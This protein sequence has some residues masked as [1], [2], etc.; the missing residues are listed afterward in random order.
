MMLLISLNFYIAEIGKEN[1]IKHIFEH[2]L[3]AVPVIVV[4]HLVGN[5]IALGFE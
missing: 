3:L 1:P 2:I 5:W 4:S